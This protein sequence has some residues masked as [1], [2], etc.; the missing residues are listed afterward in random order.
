MEYVLREVSPLDRSLLDGIFSLWEECF[1]DD[2]E[3]TAA[4][5]G[6]MPIHS[7]ICIYF[8]D[9]PV[10]MAVLLS[11]GAGYYGYAVCT[12]PDHRNKGLCK[13]IHG[14]I[15]EKCE[16]EGKEYFIHPASESLV[17]FYGSMGM[18]PVL[19]SYEVRTVGYAVKEPGSVDAGE[20]ER[21]RDLYFGG[22]P[23]Y[24]PW[25]SAAL[26]FMAENGI[27]YLSFDVDGIECAAA[28]DE[29]G[30][31][32]LCAPDYLSGRAAMAALSEM[33]GGYVRFF[34]EYDPRDSVALMSFSGQ[35]VYFN[36]FFE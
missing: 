17:S 27:K 31:I 8:G 35:S 7:T 9:I 22:T 4:F 29:G 23:T 30:I 34:G 16:K 10:S 36:L 21:I 12:S 19:S 13:K 15:R 24:F 3:F 14:Y 32:E 28:L 1:G 18:S 33:G 6:K 11:V 26:S 2:R 20:Y 5:Y 25:N